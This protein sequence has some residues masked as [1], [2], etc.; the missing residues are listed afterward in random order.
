MLR[1]LI[2]V[3]IAIPLYEALR[4]FALR[5]ARE[6]LLRR[7]RGYADQHG[8]RVDLFKF[9]GKLLVREE[10]L[11]DRSIVQAMAAAADK[12]ERPEDVRAR[13]EEY[14]DEIVPAFS[15]TAYFQFGMKLARAA[16]R[17][18][19]RPVVDAQSL[20][21]VSAALP[22]NATA[23]FLIN[24]RSN[25]DYLV[26]SW[27]LARQV[28]ISYAVGE[29]ARVF[30]LDALFKAFGGFFVRRGFPDPLYHMVLR[31]YLQLI[32]RRGVTQGIFPEGGLTRDGALR[33]PKV[34]LLDGI[35]QLSAEPGLD[36]ELYFVPVGINY[37]RVLEDEA[38]LAELRGRA[39]P[40]TRAEKLRGALRLLWVVPSRVVINVLRV[41]TG[42]LQRNGY[43]AVAFGEPIR[44]RDLPQ[45]QGLA[46]LTDDARRAIAKEVAGTLME[47]I[48]RTIPATP[49]PLLSR[50]A[51]ELKCD[52]TLSE[53]AAR[54]RE[55]RATLEERGA[56]TALG[57]EFDPQRA[58][59]A[60]LREDLDRNRDL[61]RLETDLLCSE[62]AEQ[63]VRLGLE[64]LLQ[65]RALS[66][67]KGRVRLGDHPYARDLLEYYARSLV[68]LGPAGGDPAS[69]TEARLWTSS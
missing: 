44:L 58:A 53:L 40:P 7:A 14:I 39:N 48:A 6:S 35:L 32:T 42:R 17:A 2:A 51:L 4:Y 52:A 9:G 66:L 64:R 16:I 38:L 46:A 63:I 29:W 3:A 11:N 34:G 68:L 45:A 5:K 56:R 23:V 18:V 54:V 61:A 33:A 8:V 25:F 65:R 20:Q 19:Y 43:V 27:A 28:A 24:H 59:R 41:A 57:R 12:G 50:A 1:A 36:R 21:R 30:P 62:E 67:A 10:L 60:D 37:D 31:R 22:A 69:L 55:L 15:L 26:V 49:V 13:V 47:R